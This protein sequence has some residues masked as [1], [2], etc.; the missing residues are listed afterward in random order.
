MA[1]LRTPN[2]EQSVATP[3]A[4]QRKAPAAPAPVKKLTEEQQKFVE[5]DAGVLMLEALAGTGKTSSLVEFARHRPKARILYLTF[6]ASMRDAA[7]GRFPSNVKVMTTHGPAFRHV[8]SQYADAGKLVPS[9]RPWDIIRALSLKESGDVPEAMVQLYALR[10]KETLDNFMASADPEI[11]KNHLSGNQFAQAEVRYLD[12]DKMLKQAKRAWAIMKD[13]SNKGLGMTHDGYLKLFQLGG[14]SLGGYDYVLLDEAQDSNP[15][16]LHIVLQH[17]GRKVLVG[18]SNQAIYAFRGAIDA[19]KGVKADVRLPLQSSF[20][21]GYE[22]E[23]IA[24]HLLAINKSRIMLKGV[25]GPSVVTNDKS[26]PITGITHV[27]RGNG[28]IFEKSFE[29]MLRGS[30]IGFLGGIRG[31]RFDVL[32]DVYRLYSGNE[33]KDAFLKSFTDYEELKLYAENADDRD[34]TRSSRLVEEYGI[35]IPS[36]ISNITA[37]AEDDLSRADV[38]FTTAHKSKGA[39][40]ENV[41]IGDDYYTLPFNDGPKKNRVN[42]ILQKMEEDGRGQ[43]EINISYVAVTRAIRKLYLPEDF[44]KLREIPDIRQAIDTAKQQAKSHFEQQGEQPRASSPR[45]RM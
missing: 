42:E 21:F 28:Y 32:E 24:N 9:L 20:R 4:P 3:P 31:Y 30:K 11:A 14:Y 19:M 7:L 45:P 22:V 43:E 38:V 1:I 26:V 44:E 25:G 39:E 12:P 13:T 33:P 16:A 27:S 8:G 6:N 23:D 34:L 40:F 37:N 41:L 35:K 2:P 18:D 17:N 15:A 36:M 10:I 29:A 5:T